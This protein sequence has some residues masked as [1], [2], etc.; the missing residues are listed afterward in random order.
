ML[1]FLDNV[2]SFKVYGTEYLKYRQFN[3]VL[4]AMGVVPEVLG[5]RSFEE[6]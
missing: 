6:T 4:G 3:Q 1:V 2:E 5:S